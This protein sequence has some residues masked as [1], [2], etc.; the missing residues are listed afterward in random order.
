M[1]IINNFRN[2]KCPD[3]FIGFIN[4]DKVKDKYVYFQREDYERQIVFPEKL[5]SYCCKNEIEFDDVIVIILES[6]HID[7]F[8]GFS[9]HVFGEN[10]PC[11]SRPANGTTGQNLRKYLSDVISSEI[12]LDKDLY[13]VILLNA[14]NYQCSC[15]VNTDLYRD[16]NFI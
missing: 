9:I 16:D 10:I 11:Y 3:E 2:K 12:K 14:I 13:P 7:E 4:K 1:N 8:F 6:P 5:F 15:G